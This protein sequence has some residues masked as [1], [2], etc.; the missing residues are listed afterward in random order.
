MT[1]Y[2]AITNSVLRA[3]PNLGAVRLVVIPAR[4]VVSVLE[5]ADSWLRVSWR[6]YEGWVYAPLLEK[7]VE[8]PEYEEQPE[9]VPVR[10]DV[11][12]PVG[13]PRQYLT[14]Y[15]TRNNN[16]CGQ[17][18]AA[19]IGGVGIMEFLDRWKERS[20]FNYQLFVGRDWG[21]GVPILRDMLAVF[22]REAVGWLD[23]LRDPISGVLV[24]PGRIGAALKEMDCIVGVAINGSTGLIQ[25]SGVRHWV[26]LVDVEPHGIADGI[27]TV[28]NPFNNRYEKVSYPALMESMGAW[29]TQTGLWS[30]H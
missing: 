3:G 14:L 27:V 20:P 4:S 12:P 7:I 26:C 15:K 29:S 11:R 28:Y 8:P 22:D 17:F 18:C 9:V 6:N 19:Y 13:V 21:T 5:S 30:K 25:R 2:W 23:G 24:S 10:E 1:N 16:L